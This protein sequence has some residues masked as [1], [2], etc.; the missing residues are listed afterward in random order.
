MA[1]TGREMRRLAR[2]E[3]C[4][5]SGATCC[6]EASKVSAAGPGSE[7]RRTRSDALK[8]RIAKKASEDDGRAQK[9]MLL[10]GKYYD[11][12]LKSPS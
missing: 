3:E 8:P 9:K 1:V 10:M 12:R 7:A 11:F 5:T 4:G 2:G 6:R